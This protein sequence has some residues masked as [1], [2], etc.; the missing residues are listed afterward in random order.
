[1]EETNIEQLAEELME[2]L[3]KIINGRENFITRLK[4]PTEKY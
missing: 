3:P 2:Q 4:C 1:M